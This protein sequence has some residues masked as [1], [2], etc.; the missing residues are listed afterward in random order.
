MQG[1][2]RL[3]P[4]GLYSWGFLG[5]EIRLRGQQGRVSEGW[6]IMICLTSNFLQK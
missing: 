5:L 3:L 1:L 2:C 6:V 4:S